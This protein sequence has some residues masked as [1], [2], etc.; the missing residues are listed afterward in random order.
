MEFIEKR[1]AKDRDKYYR[2][3]VRVRVEHLNF[4]KLCPRGHSDKIV[5]YLKDKFRH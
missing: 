4:G 2:G 3:T 5:E 1:L